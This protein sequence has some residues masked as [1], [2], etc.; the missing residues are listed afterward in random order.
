MWVAHK[1]RYQRVIQELTGL[2]QGVSGNH[3]YYSKINNEPIT[4]TDSWCFLM[5]NS[6][7]NA[8]TVDSAESD[9]SPV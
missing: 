8:M 2:K 5:S 9:R 1:E 3:S 4:F 6:F 7:A